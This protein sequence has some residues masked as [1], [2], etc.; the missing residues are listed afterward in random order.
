[1]SADVR[2]TP[3]DR[4]FLLGLQALPWAFAGGLLAAAV[5]EL[6]GHGILAVLLGGE[7]TGFTVE[8]NA[9]AYTYAFVDPGRPWREILYYAGGVTAAVVFGSALTLTAASQPR[10]PLLRMALLIVALHFLAGGASLVFWNACHPV[11]PGDVGMILMVTDAPWP[12]PGLIAA[13]GALLFGSV[14][15]LS[16]MLFRTAEGWISPT[17]RLTGVPRAAVLALLAAVPALLWFAVYWDTIAPGLGRTPS[18]V[19]AAAHAVTAVSL[20]WVRFR[21]RPTQSSGRHVTA[22]IAAAWIFG[23]AVLAVTALWLREGVFFD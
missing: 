11:P 22:A 15:V 1:M 7:F 17:G 21:P 10:R 23:L 8:L 16:A 9:M 6:V 18:I 12:R 13:G 14:W 2:Q 4:L 3:A 20:Y 19:G 5:R